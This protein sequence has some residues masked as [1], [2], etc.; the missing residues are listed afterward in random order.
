MHAERARLRARLLWTAIPYDGF[1]AMKIRIFEDPQAM[2]KAAADRAAE[3]I[4]NAIAVRGQARIVAS[5]GESQV[6]FLRE[7]TAH[8]DLAW[9]KVDVF[10]VG[11]YIGLPADHPASIRRFL[12]DRLITK[13]GIKQFISFE[14]DANPARMIADVG[15]KLRSIPVDVAF[16]GIGENGHLGLNNPPADFDTEDPYRVVDLDFAFRRQQVSEGWFVEVGQVPM[17]AISMPV[18]QILK[19]GE[20]LAVVPDS[21]KALAVKVCAEH[22][23][24]PTAPATILRGHPNVTM[25]LDR[26]SS[27]QLSPGVGG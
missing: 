22:G 19:A 13:A 12:Q 25:Y 18:R 21:R 11:E 3:V 15:A 2:A 6:D 17:Q 10:C 4:Q 24:S 20:I 27:A 16:V 1:I 7:L 8:R 5:A 9:A 14:G 23:I 26:D